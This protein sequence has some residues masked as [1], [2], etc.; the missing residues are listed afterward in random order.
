[1]HQ[2]YMSKKKSGLK[3]EKSACASILVWI[4][5]GMHAHASRRGMG[6]DARIVACVEA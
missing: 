5:R 2:E 1:V 4:G 3:T 6:L